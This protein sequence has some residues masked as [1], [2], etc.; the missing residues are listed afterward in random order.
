[1]ADETL[2]QSI[3]APLQQRLDRKA[4]FQAVFGT[5][6]GRQ[7]LQEILE[8]GGVFD[9]VANVSNPYDTYVREGQ[10]RLALSISKLVFESDEHMMQMARRME[11][12]YDEDMG[13]SVT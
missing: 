2:P 7:V 10:R 4:R 13:T 9:T 3:P 8:I 1:M 5:K 11:Q 6:E 12:S